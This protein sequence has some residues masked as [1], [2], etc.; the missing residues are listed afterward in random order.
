M[1]ITVSGR[2]K[3]VVTP[4]KTLQRQLST[5]SKC[6]SA[7]LVQKISTC[8]CRSSTLT[9]YDV[10]VIRSQATDTQKASQLVQAVIR[11]G[12]GSCQRF[13][14]CLSVCSPSLY[15]RVTGC[16]VSVTEEDHYHLEDISIPE[17]TGAIPPSIINIQNSL[18]TN[19][20]I[21]SNNNLLSVLSQTH[22]AHDMIEDTQRADQQMTE[23]DPTQAH[24]I[25]VERSYVEFVIIGDNNY[26][27]TGTNEDSGQQEQS[28][29]E[30][31]G[32]EG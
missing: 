22:V 24:S 16:T 32:S 28:E 25:Q 12:R 29:S 7:C 3:G 10:Q 23:Q 13:F 26:M 5:L 4:E 27:R 1:D 8:L 20:I 14:K 21:G 11:K 17:T 6:M 9:D 15:E 30:P 31:E 2:C 18:V 19:C